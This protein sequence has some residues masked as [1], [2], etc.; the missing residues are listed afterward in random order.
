MVLAGDAQEP[1]V[2]AGGH[3]DGARGAGRE[4][5]HGGAGLAVRGGPGGGHGGDVRDVFGAFLFG[6]LQAG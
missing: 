2:E 1:A 6:G 4:V 3:R 5:R